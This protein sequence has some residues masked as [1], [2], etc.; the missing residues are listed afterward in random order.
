[1]SKVLWTAAAHPRNIWAEAD[2]SSKQGSSAPNQ[3]T[4]IGV[5]PIVG[6]QFEIGADNVT[7]ATGQAPEASWIDDTPKAVLIGADK[8]VKSGPSPKL[9]ATTYSPPAIF[10]IGVSSLV[11]ATGHAR[12]CAVDV[13]EYLAA[14]TSMNE[15]WLRHP[16]AKPAPGCTFLEEVENGFTLKNAPKDASRAC[17]SLPDCIS[18]TIRDIKTSPRGPS[19]ELNVAPA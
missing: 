1:M 16:V 6:S 13:D 11:N 15:I 18:A 5:P 2:T 10:V 17:S 9:R 19:A 12:R 4:V 3:A 7:M 8:W 14:C